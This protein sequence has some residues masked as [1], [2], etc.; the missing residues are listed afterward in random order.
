[1]QVNIHYTRLSASGTIS[2]CEGLVADNGQRLTTY[3]VLT[4]AE[5]LQMSQAC[6]KS[7]M[8]PHGYLLG[9]LR[10]HY[11]YGEFFTVLE[12]FN[13]EGKLAGYYSDIATPLQKVGDDYYL[14]DLF[15]DYWLAPGQPPLA[16]D[17]DEFDEAVGAGVLTTEQIACAR[18]TFARLRE[19]IAAG[20][21]PQQYIQG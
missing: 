18:S 11:Y 8:L 9:S 20:V 5:R 14:T 16:L 3:V 17:E 1:M 7:S 19:E 2:F 6:W 12:C 15:L 4:E 10:K 21:F 13:L